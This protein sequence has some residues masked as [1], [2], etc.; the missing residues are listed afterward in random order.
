MRID[1]ETGAKIV[2][3]TDLLSLIGDRKP[4][5]GDADGASAWRRRLAA[6]AESGKLNGRMPIPLLPVRW[7]L[8]GGVRL[9]LRTYVR[10]KTVGLENVPKTGAFILTPNHSSHLDSP[11]V[12]RAISGKR[13][14]WVVGAEDYF[15]NTR[16]KRFVFGKVLDTIAFDRQADG[17]RGLRRCGGVL[18]R[19]DGLLI[20]PEGTRSVTGQLQD[21]KIGAAVLAMEQGVP[22]VPVHIH[23]AYDLL[24]KGQRIIRPGTITVTFGEPVYPPRPE[25]TSDHH[26]AFR[27]MTAQ[28][29][30]A[31]VT[32]TNGAAAR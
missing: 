10:I 3:V 32:L 4:A 15:F 20:F 14:V 30:E 24:R 12:L 5:H 8:R 6:G 9:F 17:L 21:F 22:I 25:E 19:G 16:M 7:L 13:R 11:A 29:R 1:D 27:E 28:V 26:A 2:R 23:R 31:V 18:S